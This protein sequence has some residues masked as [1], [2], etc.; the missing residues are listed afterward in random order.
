M[1]SSLLNQKAVPLSS[2]FG[3][4]LFWVSFVTHSIQL[5]YPSRCRPKGKCKYRRILKLNALSYN[6]K[7]IPS[8]SSE[9]EE[10][11]NLFFVNVMV[12][13][14]AYI[15]KYVCKQCKYFLLKGSWSLSLAG[16]Q[17]T[18]SLLRLIDRGFAKKGIFNRWFIL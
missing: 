18:F 2:H 15:N 6:F 8:S 4:T 13:S 1:R 14:S 16:Q 17:A 11:L 7:R 12:E 10:G 3:L 5:T 9:E